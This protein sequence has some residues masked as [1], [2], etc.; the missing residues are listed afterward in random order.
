MRTRGTRHAPPRRGKCQ[1]LQRRAD[2]PLGTGTGAY[3]AVG[4]GP[5][6]WGS[7]PPAGCDG[8]PGGSATAGMENPLHVGRVQSGSL[9]WSTPLSRLHFSSAQV[10]SRQ[11]LP[12]SHV[13]P[14][15]SHAPGPH[16]TNIPIP[17]PLCNIPSGC[18]FFTG[19]WTTS[20][21][22]MWRRVAA[23]CRPLRPVLLLVS[24]LHSRSPVVGMLGLCWMWRGSF[25]CFCCSTPTRGEG[26]MW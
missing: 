6:L 17:S 26:G 5:S 8:A 2:G 12:T 1:G 16:T 22:R 18:C 24:F 19:P 3:N 9:P 20:S 7:H 15:C 21:L 10:V 14:C 25:D 11:A 4:Q 13:C 23:F